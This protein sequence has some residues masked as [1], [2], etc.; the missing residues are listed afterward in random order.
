MDGKRKSGKIGKSS[1]TCK[2]HLINLIKTLLLL[3]T[4]FF[5]LTELN[6]APQKMLKQTYICLKLRS[7]FIFFVPK[8]LLILLPLCYHLFYG[9][10]IFDPC[11]LFSILSR[12]YGPIQ[13]TQIQASKALR[14]QAMQMSTCLSRPVVSIHSSHLLAFG[15]VNQLTN[16]LQV[17][18]Y[19]NLVFAPLNGMNASYSS[20]NFFLVQGL[21]TQ[22]DRN[23]PPPKPRSLVSFNTEVHLHTI[24][25]DNHEYYLYFL[26]CCL[27]KQSTLI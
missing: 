24:T 19:L 8:F 7:S 10:F 25:M 23:S 11:L 21:I 26:V 2:Y 14:T 20:F 12:F 6:Y 5:I 3:L 18:Y 15:L 16:L 9:W 17:Y 22:V 27:N 1:P 13:I 4:P